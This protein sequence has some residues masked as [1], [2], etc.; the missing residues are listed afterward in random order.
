MKKYLIFLSLLFVVSL[1][2]IG[3]SNCKISHFYQSATKIDITDV[4]YGTPYDIVLVV[5]YNPLE[6]A[7]DQLRVVLQLPAGDNS[8]VTAVINANPIVIS[9]QILNY[10][11]NLLTVDITGFSKMLQSTFTINVYH[12][13]IAAVAA[14]T[15]IAYTATSSLQYYSSTNETPVDFPNNQFSS[16]INGKHLVGSITTSLLFNQFYYSSSKDA[17]KPLYVDLQVDAGSNTYPTSTILLNLNSN[18]T[19]KNVTAQNSIA[20]TVT[21]GS[22]LYYSV[23]YGELV[24]VYFDLPEN[25]SPITLTLTGEAM[26]SACQGT[27]FPFTP[28]SVSFTGKPDN[29]ILTYPSIYTSYNYLETG[30]SY[31]GCGGEIG[32]SIYLDNIY[33]S[34]IT[35][36]QPIVLTA[37]ISGNLQAQNIVFTGTAIPN[38]VFIQICGNTTYETTPLTYN[39]DGSYTI[40]S[41]LIINKV[42]MEFLHLDAN[43]SFLTVN[44]TSISGNQCMGSSPSVV[45][46][47]LKNEQ[48]Y[49]T[50]TYGLSLAIPTNDI[51]VHYP[52]Q[53]ILIPNQEI[54]PYYLSLQVNKTLQPSD[55]LS[56]T[57]SDNMTF[58]ADYNLELGFDNTSFI[59]IASF[60][61]QYFNAN[62]IKY[63]ISLDRKTLTITNITILGARSDCSTLPYNLS[64]QVT[65]QV[66]SKPT[67][68]SNTNVFAL[69]NASGVDLIPN[70]TYTWIVGS[71]QSVTPTVLFS[72]DGGVTKKTGITIKKNDAVNVYYTLQNTNL[73][74]YDQK[75]ITFYCILPTNGVQ[76]SSLLL[77]QTK[78]SGTTLIPS[79]IPSNLYTVSYANGSL[80]S[81]LTLTYSSSVVSNTNIL[82]VNIPSITV[83]GYD[84][85]ELVLAYPVNL[86]LSSNNGVRF[87]TNIDGLIIPP[88]SSTL[89]IGPKSDCDLFDCADCVTSFSPIAGNVYYLSA[90]VKEE[91]DQTYVP[92]SKYVNSGIQIT[93]NDGQIATLP[94]YQGSGPIVEGWQRIEGSFQVPG[95]ASNIQVILT[96]LNASGGGNTY[97]DDIRIHPINSNMKSFVYNPST[98]K[99]VAELDENNFATIYEYD[100]E[101]ILVRV[102]KE[103]ERGIM[104][105]KETRTNQSKVQTNALK[106][107]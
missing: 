70:A 5:N 52:T 18:V 77:V 82:Q 8:S 30:T 86:G 25:S 24:R 101:G 106:E 27:V 32:P 102:K 44:C 99:L 34:P 43:T 66:V 47:L 22:K 16:T 53:N 71:T 96:N 13:Q 105:I 61:A 41:N 80:D 89:T 21:I 15:P 2:G 54:T 38:K 36:Q 33:N 19:I 69:K 20:Q 84:K 91:Y 9:S 51:I 29:A 46:T 64:I 94:L 49:I 98:Q 92:P 7:T 57:L 37:D 60:N 75:S 6:Q 68:I 3:Q 62:P 85:L 31:D 58:P 56:Y 45:F 72:C 78:T 73:Y 48:P 59:P 35:V 74:E 12:A 100:D 87:Y 88:Q 81:Y 17:K 11:Q 28:I 10:N 40:P 39:N 55:Y 63:T 26:F 14:C 83:D 95:G 104:T 107:E 1:Q 90:W 23:P 93:F 76:P 97:F 79:I 65:T 50:E 67:S 4:V 103:T 42:R